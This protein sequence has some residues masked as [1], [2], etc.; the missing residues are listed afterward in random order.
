MCSDRARRQSRQVSCE[1]PASA[2]TTSHQLGL[3]CLTCPCCR[4][5]TFS[6]MG[7]KTL[8]FS[9]GHFFFFKNDNLLVLEM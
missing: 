7:K 9:K 5:S 6:V 1:L 3:W 8:S 2:T 4:A